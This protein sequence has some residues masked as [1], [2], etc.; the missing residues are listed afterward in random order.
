MLS[1]V[2][3]CENNGPSYSDLGTNRIVAMNRSMVN[4]DL[5]AWCGK[6]VKVFLGDGTEVEYDEPLVLWDVCE[7][8]ETAPIIDFSVDFY[9][10]LMENGDCMS[11]NGNNPAGLKIQIVDNQIWAPAPGSNSY[12]PTAAS[13]IY[14]GGGY[15]GI[16]PK[17]TE[18]PAWGDGKGV[19]KAGQRPL[20]VAT[21]AATT[22]ETTS[23]GAVSN[24]QVASSGAVQTSTGAL[25]AVQTSTALDGTCTKGEQKCE[26][27]QLFICNYISN[28]ADGL[29]WALQSECP[30][31][32]DTSSQ[33]IC[34]SQ[35]KRR[36]LV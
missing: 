21:A 34:K 24:E 17:N 14:S 27:N 35:R 2:P 28:S 7:A 6:E 12:S 26:N 8:A 10:N 36:G 25:G 11:N 16:N 23:A 22:I 33:N 20:T 19:D 30:G 32:C 31:G 13:T 1:S 29:T 3:H 4:G 15:N 9:L 18:I 5:S